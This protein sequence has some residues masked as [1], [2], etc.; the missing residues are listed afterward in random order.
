MEVFGKGRVLPDFFSLSNR[1]KPRAMRHHQMLLAMKLTVFLLTVALVQV[2]AAAFSQNVTLSG[3]DLPLKYVFKTIKAQTGYTFFYNNELLKDAKPVT[4]NVKDA[5]LEIVLGLCFKDQPLGYDIQNKTVFVTRKVETPPINSTTVLQSVDSLPPAK[6]KVKGVV[7]TEAGVP[8]QGANVTV[9][10]TE[11]GTITNA[12]GEFELSYAIPEGSVLIFSFVGYAPQNFTVKDGGQIRIYMKVAQNELDKAVVKAYG[13]TTQRLTTA[14]IGTVTAEEIERQPVMNPLLALEGKVAGLDVNM[15]SGYASAPVKVELRGRASIGISPSQTFPSDPLY[16]I[17]GVPLTVNEVSGLS[18]YTT[19]SYGFDQNGMS[20]AGGQSPF[21]SINPA[22]IESIE[23]LKDADATAIYGSRG[24]NGVILV[25]TKKGKAGKTKFD[26]HTQEGTTHVDRFWDMMNT[27]QYLAMRRQAFYNSGTAPDP[28]YDYDVNGTWDTTRY[29][30]W[31]KVLYGGMGRTVDIQGSLSGGDAHTIFRVGA[32]YNRTTGITTV[33]GADQRGSVSLS[34]T[35]HSLDQRLSISS[36]SGF[37]YAQSNLISLPGNAL[38]PPDAPPIYDSVGNLNWAGWGGKD[39]N[40]AAE[41]SCPFGSLKIPYTA[42][43]NLLNSN[44]VIGYELIRG[45]QVSASVGYNIAQQNQEQQVPIASQDPLRSPIG[46]LNIGNNRNVNWIVEPQLTYNSEISKGKLS[47]LLGASS[48]QNNTETEF[49]SGT[50][51]QS[52]LLI[53]NLSSA[54]SFRASDL[55]GEYRYFGVFGRV[56]YNWENKYILNLNARRDGSSKFGPGKQFGNFGSA[57]AAWIASEEEWLKQILPSN[58]S[59]IKLRGS[60]GT[61]GSDAIP[62]YGYLSQYSSNQVLPYNGSSALVPLIDPNPSFRWQSNKELEGAINLG[63]LKDRITT[64]VA[65]YRN[66]CGN[67]LIQFPTPLFTGFSSVIE[68]SPALVQN[69]GWEFTVSANLIKLKKFSWTVNFNMAINRNKLVSY[70]D[71]A[72]SP[73]T[74]TL[75]V[76]QPLNITNV[77]HY[78]G[79][80]PQTGNYSFLDRN[81]DGQIVWNPGYPNDDSY[82]LVLAPKYFGGFGMNFAYGGLTANLFFNFKNQ[83]GQNAYTKFVNPPGFANFNQPEAIWGKQWQYPGDKSAS[84]TKF[85]TV[86]SQLDGWFALN[87]DGAN[88]SASFVR[89]SNLSIAYALPSNYLKKAGIQGC[90]LFF[91]TNNLFI[92][93]KYKGLDPETQNFGGLPPVKE[94]VGGIN[95]NF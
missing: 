60:F 6:I 87:S 76:G 20:P 11:K 57:G 30:N 17:D 64:Q 52:D 56:S 22:D 75:K 19:G 33:S 83:I 24:A 27:T 73:F 67:Q 41:N 26:L 68:N 4:L 34:L 51:Y 84:V 77:L 12:K 1:I 14:D 31:Q 8:V 45:L 38:I 91:H 5:P 78:I 88:T 55:Y 9:K 42:K 54:P 49:T 89:L 39:Q 43:T 25:T 95:F 74:A 70:P 23:V 69:T 50:G 65:W 86:Y 62:S 40:S 81:H 85:T 21:F 37:S 92:I 3:K 66:R 16:I 47:V 72:Q 94:I 46:T 28:V 59:F 80:D 90:S 36:T 61:T 32:G 58:I 48:S 71:F 35:H 13:I 53:D 79:I 93:T 10:Q 2:R 44:L 63:F 18:S 7:L 15:T 29:T 82:P